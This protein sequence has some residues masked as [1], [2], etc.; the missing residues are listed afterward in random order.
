MLKNKFLLLSV[1]ACIGAISLNNCYANGY[2]SATPKKPCSNQ[3]NAYLESAQDYY[4]Y[5][6]AKGG[7]A[8]TSSSSDWDGYFAGAN[9]WQPSQTSRYSP[10]VGASFGY[11]FANSPLQVGLSYYY[12]GDRYFEWQPING[13]NPHSEGKINFYSNVFLL[14]AYFNIYTNSNFTPY[15]GLG[16]G[17]NLNDSRTYWHDNTGKNLYSADENRFG[18][19]YNGVIGANY[20]FN[21][22]WV[23]NL[24]FNYLNLNKTSDA[25]PILSPVILE[26][27]RFHVTTGTLGISY[28]F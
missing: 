11:K 9:I 27:H 1:C 8:I 12:I 17:G 18:D 16:I 5:L 23:L 22:N 28:R 20:A 21:Q 7:G 15:I 26:G 25:D 6:T 14:N 13:L 10:V 19:A 3:G 24:E 4:F 2:Y